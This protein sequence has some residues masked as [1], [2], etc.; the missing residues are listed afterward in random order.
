MEPDEPG[1][2]GFPPVALRRLPP[3]RSR[4]SFVTLSGPQVLPQCLGHLHL[5]I[6]RQPVPDF[7]G[8][9]HRKAG[10][11]LAASVRDNK[12]LLLGR[13]SNLSPS[14]SPIDLLL[15]KS[16]VLI[17]T[18]PACDQSLSPPGGFGEIGGQS[19][20][21]PGPP[22]PSPGPAEVRFQQGVC[23]TR[24]LSRRESLRCKV[25]PRV[26]RGN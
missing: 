11:A 14:Q 13:E 22:V 24:G 3:D 19:R 15:I 12:V 1:R 20:E 16:D 2:I 26:T 25:E 9:H 23:K 7:V 8:R 4:R 10:A 6:H 18:S 5:A 21:G 17:S